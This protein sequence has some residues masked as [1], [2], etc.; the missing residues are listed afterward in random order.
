MNSR[1][2]FAGIVGSVAMLASVLFPAASAQAQGLPGASEVAN[3]FQAPALPDFNQLVRQFD[4]R[5]REGAWEIRN[6]LV[7]QAN[8]LNPQFGGGV[9]QSIDQALDVVF[10]GLVAQKQEA[11]RAAQGPAEPMTPAPEQGPH[12]DT[13][14]CPADARVCVDIDG[15]RTWLQDGHGKVTHV[16]SAMAPGK[17]GQDTPR[18]TFNVNRKVKDEISYAFNNAPMPYAIYF[19]NN[20]HAFH[21]GSPAYDSAGCVRLPNQDA[22]AF[23]NHLNIGDKVFIY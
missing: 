19:T 15:R 12:I 7:H 22:I 8:T 17:P 10:P 13:G 21:E 16:A 20:G 2:L 6:Q 9:A 4:Q 18:G 23:W 11:T 3:N 5:N 14:A 1:K